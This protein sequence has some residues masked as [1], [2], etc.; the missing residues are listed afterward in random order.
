MQPPGYWDEVGV[1]VALAWGLVWPHTIYQPRT[2]HDTKR[3]LYSSTTGA[4]QPTHHTTQ[5]QDS[6]KTRTQQPCTQR[7][8]TRTLHALQLNTHTTRHDH[9]TTNNNIAHQHTTTSEQQPQKYTTNACDIKTRPT[10]VQHYAYAALSGL[11]CVHYGMEARAL[12]INRGQFS[13]CCQLRQSKRRKCVWRVCVGSAWLS[14]IL[15]ARR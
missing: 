2:Q 12:L 9:N 11:S 1:G 8:T 10:P 6:S 7:G 3:T 5:T 13:V 14:Q 15:Y 4:P